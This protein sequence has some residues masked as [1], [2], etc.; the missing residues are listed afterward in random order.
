MLSF[1]SV[2]SRNVNL[3]DEQCCLNSTKYLWHSSANREILNESIIIKNFDHFNELNFN[4][5]GITIKTYALILI[6]NY[7]V[8]LDN[9][10]RINNLLY[11]V[12]FRENKF[13]FLYNLK[14]FNFV[15]YKS[16]YK[17]LNEYKV[18][19]QFSRFQFYIN[20]SL[21]DENLCKFSNFNN[22][23]IEFFGTIKILLM[24][25]DIYYSKLT[26]PY[27]FMN[28]KLIGLTLNQISNSL[29]LKNQLG[30]IDINQTND[31]DLKNEDFFYL[32]IAITYE[33]LSLRMLNRYVFKHIKRL[34][35]WGI[36][37]DVETDLFKHFK[38]FKFLSTNLQNMKQLLENNNK[39]MKYINYHAKVNI[40]DMNE[41][42]K[43]IKKVLI[44]EIVQKNGNTGSYTTFNKA[45]LY[46]DEDFC[47]FEHFPHENLVY[48]FIVSGA[49]LKCTCTI[50]WLI[51]NSDLYFQDNFKNF[52]NNE[53]QIKYEYKFPDNFFNHTV[54]HCMMTNFKKSLRSCEFEKRLKACNK[55]SYTYSESFHFNN[56]IDILFLIKWVQ[57]IVFEFLQPILCVV[58]II[59]NLLSIFTLRHQMK[60]DLDVK[61][62]S[63]YNHIF[64]NSIFNLIYCV[65]T[66][67]GLI[68]V[69]VF[70]VS[71]FC[72]R[73]Y[74]VQVSQYFRIIFIYFIGNFT[75]LC[76]NI[77]YLS[78]ALS[79]LFQSTKQKKGLL[80]RFNKM[81]L[82]WYYFIICLLS[83]LLSIFRL[84][85]YKINYIEN[86][87]K[88]FPLETYDF[89]S[90]KKND[91]HCHLYRALNVINDFIKDILFFIINLIID[92][93]MYKN[94]IKNLEN[95]RKLT[96]D[97]K[98]I[99]L[100]IKYKNSVNQMIFVNGFVFFIAYFPEFITNILLIALDK[101]ISMFCFTYISCNIISELAQFFNFISISFQFFVCKKFNK[102]F[103]KSF[104]SLKKMPFFKWKFRPDNSNQSKDNF[105][106]PSLENTKF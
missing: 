81:N 53:Y 2:S 98:H 21:V 7:A 48:P 63:M 86:S 20:T 56:D 58:G 73:I 68:N 84:F 22:S 57:L 72:S 30:F 1:E 45:Y 31:L 35:V 91:F 104:N 69:C 51:Q 36:I 25:T 78:F 70:N 38:N 28:T 6:P 106:E 88:N 14:G 49:L 41:I 77:S 102:R 76:C 54:K 4:C 43:N 24:D 42:N 60:T 80:N 52:K 67:M 87:T 100:A 12:K 39:W 90:C 97:R 9:T 79:R 40:S 71:I 85:E 74:Q 62:Y 18:T 32:N 93:F 105:V 33:K 95:K 89:G 55:T 44:F 10:F 27:V 61:D 101:Y 5:T 65:I 82:K 59:T 13:I 23:K 16:I 11:S 103:S 99:N 64:M 8:L 34:V 66:L 3:K 19:V 92:I 83:L 50:Y 26:C 46:P 15:N 96:N 37:Y 17:Y 94:S 47:L 29:I 75:K